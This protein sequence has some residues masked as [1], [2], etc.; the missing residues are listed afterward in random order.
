MKKKVA[1]IDLGTNTFHILVGTI[2]EDNF[3]I[4]Y[5]E[6]RAVKIGKGGINE[7]IITDQ[8]KQRALTTLSEFKKIIEKENIDII[9]T[10]ATS[11][12]RNA[13]NGQQLANQIKERTGIEV[14]IISG[15]EEAALIQYGVNKALNIGTTPSLIIDI[16]GGSVEFIICNN[17]KTFWK[18]SFEIGAQRLVELFHQ[19]DPIS[20]EEINALEA[21]LQ[22]E[23]TELDKNIKKFKPEILIGSSGTFETLSDIHRLAHKIEK[24]PETTELPITLSSYLDIHQNLLS[25][26]QRERLAIPGMV[27]MRVEMIVVASCIIHFLIKKY[28]FSKMRISAYALKEGVLNK[29]IDE[30][31]GTIP[32]I[33]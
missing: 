8:A 19:N 4:L 29:L 22:E 11:A 31:K 20:L 12:F 6:K 28:G 25:K 18:N 9:H 33:K 5:K 14:K 3:K 1:I 23:L 26:N 24:V 17:K 32:Q 30:L 16:G 15:K 10:T 2:F 13:L 21:Y 7:G 27:E